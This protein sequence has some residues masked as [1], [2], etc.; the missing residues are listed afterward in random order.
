MPGGILLLNLKLSNLFA[1]LIMQS[2]KIKYNWYDFVDSGEC[3]KIATCM[4]CGA[5][6]GHDE[7]TYRVTQ[8]RK[9]RS[10]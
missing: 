5:A 10:K 3:N 6:G 7:E 8:S 2:A 4:L 1:E 9:G